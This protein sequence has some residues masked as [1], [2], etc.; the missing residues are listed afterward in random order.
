M[1][2]LKLDNAYDDLVIFH[3]CTFFDINILVQNQKYKKCFM[4]LLWTIEFLFFWHNNLLH[5]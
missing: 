4:K 1:N 5:I 2:S 3:M